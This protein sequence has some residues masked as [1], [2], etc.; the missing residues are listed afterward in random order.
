MMSFPHAIGNNARAA[1][2]A[3]PT[4]TPASRVAMRRK[5]TSSASVEFNTA[6]TWAILRK[7][8]LGPFAGGNPRPPTKDR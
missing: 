3:L 4:A 7:I 1:V 8:Q 5:K 2:G 6:N